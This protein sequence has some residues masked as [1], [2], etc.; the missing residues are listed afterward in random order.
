MRL[1]DE[2]T[3]KY[4][5]FVERIAER[6]YR[7]TSKRDL[8][9]E[10]LRPAGSAGTP[11]PAVLWIHGGGWGWRGTYGGHRESMQIAVAARGYCAIGVEFRLSTDAPFPAQ[12]VDIRAAIDWIKQHSGELEIDPERIGVW[13]R[14]AGGHLAALIGVGLDFRASA[15]GAYGI[16]P[17]DFVVGT[18][19]VQSVASC[20]GPTDLS[21]I[22]ESIDP[23]RAQHIRKISRPF[24]GGELEERKALVDAA[25]PLRYVDGGEPPFLF[26][27]GR[28]DRTIPFSQA[29][30]LHNKLLES[31]CESTLLAVESAGHGL[32]P[33][34]S[35]STIDP[36]LEEVHRRIRAYFDRTLDH[37]PI[38]EVVEIEAKAEAEI[39]TRTDG[40]LK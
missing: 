38:P 29:E 30:I 27:H 40:A 36:P 39:E 28:N 3:R 35:G 4:E 37:T 26:V 10:V 16:E 19:E 9:L 2:I 22:C 33:E 11:I 1:P 7:R 24:F 32:L 25:N 5:M 15:Q 23:E 12:I 21:T 34:P 13:G 20:F 14:S 31:G 18:P 8:N 6:V 17:G